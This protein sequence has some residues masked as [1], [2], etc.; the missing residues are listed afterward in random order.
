MAVMHTHPFIKELLRQ[1][2]IDPTYTQRVTID[3]RV[4]DAVT[5]TVQELA[6]VSDHGPGVWPV[7]T[8]NFRLMELKETPPGADNQSVDENHGDC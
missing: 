1:L 7:D 3:I 6:H 2:G 5:V 4:D 8:R